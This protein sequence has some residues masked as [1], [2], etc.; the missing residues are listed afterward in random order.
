MGTGDLVSFRLEKR[1]RK[2]AA[3]AKRPATA[4]SPT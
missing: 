4:A 1:N 2:R 3:K